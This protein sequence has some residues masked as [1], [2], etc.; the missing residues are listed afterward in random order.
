MRTVYKTVGFY[1]IMRVAAKMLMKDQIFEIFSEAMRN[2]VME[3]ATD[4]NLSDLGMAI[5]AN[6]LIGVNMYLLRNCFYSFIL[7]SLAD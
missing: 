4:K 6:A 2:Y 3:D 1:L 5:E 7:E